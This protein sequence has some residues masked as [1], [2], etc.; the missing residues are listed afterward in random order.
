MHVVREEVK[1]TTHPGR[2]LSVARKPLASST[3][4]V[5]G[6][7]DSRK[8]FF[9]DAYKAG[10][11]KVSHSS[12]VASDNMPFHKFAGSRMDSALRAMMYGC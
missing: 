4:E 3:N 6:A 9:S 1:A 8:I 11:E 5:S 7:P 2:E 12:V 10:V